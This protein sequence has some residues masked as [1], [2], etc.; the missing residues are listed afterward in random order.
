MLEP[1]YYYDSVF[2]IPYPK[3]W[4]KG[5]RGLIFDVDNTLTPFDQPGPPEKITEL[6]GELK[7]KGFRVCL[8]TNNTNRRLGSFNETLKLPGIANAAKPLT[9]GIRYA[10]RQMETTPEQTAIIGDQVL[11]DVWAGK[12]ARITTILVKPI[13]ERDFF[14]VRWKRHI[15]RFILRKYFAAL[16]EEDG[17]TDEE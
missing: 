17:K 4:E 5:I 16:K 10:M 12:N 8:V 6:V 7:E 1:D 9:R 2:H 15:E 13:T 3:L 14:F 11:S